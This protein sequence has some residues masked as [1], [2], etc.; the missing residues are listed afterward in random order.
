M[1]EGLILE[2]W[3][4]KKMTDAK[5]EKYKKETDCFFKRR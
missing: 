4:R 1:N 3:W 5:K 2:G